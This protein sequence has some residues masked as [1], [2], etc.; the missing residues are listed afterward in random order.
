MA[1]VASS[2]LFKIYTFNI[3]FI[4][5]QQF[6]NCWSSLFFHKRNNL[7]CNMDCFMVINVKP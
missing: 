5:G 1:G 3:E 4:R 6:W 7:I 2:V